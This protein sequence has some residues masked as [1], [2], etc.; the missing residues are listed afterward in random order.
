MRGSF[1]VAP[2][3]YR[4]ASGAFQ[5]PI[6]LG[7]CVRSFDPSKPGSH[8]LHIIEQAPGIFPNKAN[9]PPNRNDG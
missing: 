9:S 7:M 4:Q 2:T 8:K 1:Q 6:V 3:A 5:D